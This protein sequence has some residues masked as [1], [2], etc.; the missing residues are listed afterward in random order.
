MKV[1]QS[2]RRIPASELA[3]LPKGLPALRRWLKAMGAK[4]MDAATKRRLIAAG[5]WGM[6]K[7]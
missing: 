7:E 4:P 2:I 6:P 5:E 3:G 1:K